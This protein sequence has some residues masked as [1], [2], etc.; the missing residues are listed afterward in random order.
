MRRALPF[1]VLALAALAGQA[2]YPMT[3]VLEVRTGQQRQRIDCITQDA[4][5]LIWAGGEGGLFR[6]DGEQVEVI[7]RPGR[8]VAIAPDGATVV[9][10]TDQ[11]LVLRCGGIRCDTLLYDPTLTGASSLVVDGQG[12]VWLGTY[13][14]GLWR[15]GGGAAVQWDA[16]K[17]LPDDHVNALVALP[18]SGIVAATDQGLAFCDTLGITQVVD[19]S[20]GAPDNLVLALAMDEEGRL[21]AGT[22][23]RGV[24]RWSP[25]EGVS[26]MDGPWPYG[27]VHRLAAGGGMLWA[28]T[29]EQGPVII[30]LELDNGAYRPTEHW[31]PVH[32]M[33]RAADGAVWW[34]D[35]TEALKRADPAFLVIPEH[36]GM[37]LRSIT[38][39]C[40]D[41]QRRI[42]FATTQGI[43]LHDAG[44]GEASRVRRMA[45]EVDA[46]TPVVSL[47]AGPD[48]TMWAATFG[49]GVIALRPDGA[50]QR[51]LEADGLSNRNVL[52]ARPSAE[53]VVFATLE[54]ITV[55]GSSGLRRMAPE[56]GFVFDAL[57]A[58][59]RWLMATDG[60]GVRALADGAAVSRELL[61]GS[62]FSMLRD[63]R[64]RVWA[65]GPGSGFCRADEPG[66]ACLGARLPAF[67]GDLYGLGEAAGRIIAFTSNGA[68]ALDP[69][70]GALTDVT[71][72]FG[73]DGA[74]AELNALAADDRGALWFA[75]SKGLV[76]MRPRATHFQQALR[77]AILGLN[78]SGEPVPIDAAV[79]TPHDRS[80][81]ALRFTATHWAD[82]A[83]VRFQY[84]L[85]G[86][87]DAITETRDRQAAFPA[88]RPG[89]Y[90]F[91]VRAHTGTPLTEAPWEELV[92]VVEPP[93]WRRPW[94]MAIAG[95]LTILLI[96]LVVRA[97]ERR[98]RYRDRMEQEKVR[99]QLEALRSQVDPHFLFNSFNAL[100]ELIESE[101]GKAVEHVEQLSVFF[102]NIL[103]VR[104][105]ER[106]TVEEELR[107]LDNYFALE[108]RRFG[109]AIALRREV[110]PEALRKGVV[111][112]T[113]QLLV[114]NALKHNVVTG[115]APFVIT[116]RIGDG[117]IEVRNPLRPRATAPRSTGFGLESITKRYAALTERP[118]A[119]GPADGEF[120][121]RI[122]LLDATS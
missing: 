104:D 55:A 60:K 90:V 64:S 85:L 25:T 74:T 120:I 39:V 20:N 6:T 75:C 24:F 51:F 114:E 29:K 72:V 31:P 97:R 76:R 84:R 82:P 36:E 48:G 26:R 63:S 87:S 40:T 14:K 10:A 116:V 21:W 17:G 32:G 28:G 71:T 43:Y 102:R 61:Q 73:L 69:A 83:A 56:A 45:V 93:W 101:P 92:I 66:A 95:A 35:G 58:G 107:L 34:C 65:I 38:A 100:V 67:E 27:A 42:W 121:V 89:R 77:T 94:V 2:Q 30:D 41:G 15:L 119:A 117:A 1:L 110:D 4:R 106:I 5:G 105:R 37:D 23:R 86:Y 7:A 68:L 47:A 112:L 18:G 98:L 62:Y 46:R 96:V 103:Q 3:R 16:R 57:R 22:D 109:E 33:L 91:Q 99:F 79:R 70:S 88:L 113:L 50:V 108:Q 11:G 8:V 49:A 81:I 13:G 53:G 111:P 78:V 19:E 52:C 44:F 115:G 122:P 118:I 12:A 54:G 9:A 80:T 59:D